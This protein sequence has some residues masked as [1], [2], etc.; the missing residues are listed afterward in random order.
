MVRFL[1]LKQVLVEFIIP[2]LS[3]K[4]ILYQNCPISPKGLNQNQKKQSF[5]R[6][7]ICLV[8]K[9]LDQNIIGA[10]KNAK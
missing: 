4:Y 5:V 10:P 6:V 9:T 7:F 3:L 2:N 8:L 1:N